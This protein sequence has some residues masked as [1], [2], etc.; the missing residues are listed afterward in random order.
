[1]KTVSFPSELAGV[2]QHKFEVLGRVLFVF[3]VKSNQFY[4]PPTVLIWMDVQGRWT[5][6]FM[7]LTHELYKCAISLSLLTR[8]T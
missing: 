1:M 5:A 6:Y 2:K 7:V 3:C 4:F 8:D